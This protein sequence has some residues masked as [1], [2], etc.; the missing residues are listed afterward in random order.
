VSNPDSALFANPEQRDY[1]LRPDAPVIDKAG[2]AKVGESDRDFEKDPRVVGPASDIGG[3]EFVNRPPTAVLT[4]NPAKARENQ[5]VTFDGSKSADPEAAF[6]GSI[7]GYRW[8]FGDGTIQNTQIPVVTHK[9]AQRAVYTATLTTIDN[10]AGLSAPTAAQIEVVDGNG[11]A[12]TIA[13]PKAGQKIPVTFISGRKSK[14]PTSSKPAA[15][16]PATARKAAATP[17]ARTGKPGTTSTPKSKVLGGKLRAPLLRFSGT[18]NDDSGIAG[19]QIALRRFSSGR[20]V[21][22]K[23]PRKQCTFFDGKGKFLRLPCKKPRYFY[24]ALK[25]PTEWAYRIKRGTFMRTGTYVLI[26]RAFDKLGNV[27]TPV[28]VRFRLG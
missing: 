28:T 6:G 9:Y 8:D 16:K 5:V 12:V 4:V 25:S 26:V 27:S 1:H 3:D 21:R 2:P 7:V 17:N 18:A 11:P 13:S 22:A 23:S 24:A 14:K 20:P 10:K 15:K 19:V